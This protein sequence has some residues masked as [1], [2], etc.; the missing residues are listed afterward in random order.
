VTLVAVRLS[1]VCAALAGM[2][3]LTMTSPVGASAAP[4]APKSTASVAAVDIAPTARAPQQTELQRRTG[5][6]VTIDDVEPAALVKGHPLRLTGTVSNDGTTHWEQAQVYLEVGGTPATTRDEL[7]AFATQEYVNGTRL[8]DLRLFDQ[9]GAVRPG[10]AKSY[11]LKVPFRQLPIE[12]TPGV[13]H[14][15]VSVLAGNREGRDAEA[16]AIAN[17]VIP[18][19]PTRSHSRFRPTSVA[20]LLPLTAPVL[21]QNNGNF[22]DDRLRNALSAGGRLRNVLKFARRAPPNTLQVVL[23]PALRDAVE[24]MSNGYVVQTL[25]QTARGRPG[26]KGTGQRQAA[27]WL[28]KLSAVGRRQHV[29]LLMWGAPD[30]SVLAANHIPGVAKSAVEASRTYAI[31]TS[32]DTAVVGW[33]PRGFST[34]PGLAV[35]RRSGTSVEIVDER[36][37]T[38]LSAGDS[39]YPPAVVS[40]PTHGGPLTAAVSRG[41]VAGAPLTAHTSALELRQR[42]LAEATVRSLVHD[43]QARR[44]IVALPF[45]WNPGLSGMTADLA[46]AYQLSVLRPATVAGISERTTPTPYRGPLRVPAQLS[47]YPA[48]VLRAIVTLRHN[49]RVLTSLL[50]RG[51]AATVLLNQR[52]GVAGSSAWRNLPRIATAMLQ[53]QAAAF[54]HQ[55]AKV[56]VTGPAFVALSSAT[57]RFPLTVTNGLH[58]PIRVGVKV[59][60]LNPALQVN[61]IDSLALAAGQRRDVQVVSHARGSGLTQV[62]VRL[63]TPNHRLFGARWSFNVRAT[64]FGVVIWIFMGAGGAVLFGAA[65]LRIYRRIRNSRGS[66]SASA[67]PAAP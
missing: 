33:Q 56:T 54:A 10:E 1:S 64:Q 36:S 5:L 23:D 48:Q 29:S 51:T 9:I 32:L 31:S 16:D 7:N 43:R 50:T 11:R 46:D 42:V 17:T 45:N 57:G 15:G 40:V 38:Q 47:A 34:R 41:D 59:H 14:I 28:R 62:R 30:P 60:P 13:Y 2:A 58:V 37:L 3:A 4:L 21:R 25:S 49:G 26:R 67:S 22:I 24:A 66:S 35:M 61:S 8:I 6:T 39:G 63:A 55:I 52:L 53:E 20:T 19:L 65:G 18:L 27:S 12:G 44:V